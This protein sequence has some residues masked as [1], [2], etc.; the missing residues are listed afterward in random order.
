M[1][2]IYA[3]TIKVI[4]GEDA[5]HSHRLSFRPGALMLDR[6]TGRSPIAKELFYQ[7]LEENTRKLLKQLDLKGVATTDT[8]K[9]GSYLSAIKYL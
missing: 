8:L 1:E 9:S 3:R 2:P 7:S 5:L 4:S 6:L